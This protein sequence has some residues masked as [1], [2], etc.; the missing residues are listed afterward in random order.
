VTVA[1]FDFVEARDPVHKTAG[2]RTFVLI[3]DPAHSG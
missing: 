2:Q 1:D 3:F